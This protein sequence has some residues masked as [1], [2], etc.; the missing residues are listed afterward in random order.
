MGAALLLALFDE[1]GG[2]RPPHAQVVGGLRVS[3]L[4]VHPG[5]AEVTGDEVRVF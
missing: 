5:R 3:G 4:T 2:G 1:A